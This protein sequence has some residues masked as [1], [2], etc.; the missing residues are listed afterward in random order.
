MLKRVDDAIKSYDDKA[1][2][3]VGH[4]DNVPISGALQKTYATN[5]ELSV[6]RATTVVRF[7]QEAG[8]EPERLLSTGRAEYAPVAANDIP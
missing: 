6:A 5:W 4:N 1:I 2:S 3:V 8:I 7:L